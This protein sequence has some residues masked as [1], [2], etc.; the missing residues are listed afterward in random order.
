M[1]DQVLIIVV[2]ASVIA[3]AFV[4]FKR[5]FVD[6]KRAPLQHPGQHDALDVEMPQLSAVE[7]RCLQTLQQV[8]GSEYYIRNKLTLG[9]LCPS[10]K[11]PMQLVDF[12]LFCKKDHT[13]VCVLQ[14]QSP[15]ASHESSMAEALQQAGIALYQLPRKSNYS[16]LNM[17]ETLHLH[18]KTP[19]PSAD[20]MI[21]TISMQSFRPCPQCQSQMNIKRS[22]SGAYKG[23]LF[24]VCSAYPDCDGVELYTDKS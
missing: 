24:W 19:V 6:V 2:I 3:I 15:S 18:L 11:N 23:A 1:P 21:S 17:R 9:E 12:S 7:Q 20:E 10:A 8:A 14:L 4:L 16:I 22:K 13:V 5:L